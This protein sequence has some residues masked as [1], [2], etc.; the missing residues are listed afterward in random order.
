MSKTNPKANAIEAWIT[1]H[2]KKIEKELK[3]IKR[4][5]HNLKQKAAQPE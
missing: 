2:I 5:S 4:L 1:I 3:E